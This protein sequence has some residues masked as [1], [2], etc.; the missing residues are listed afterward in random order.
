MNAALLL[1]KLSDIARLY[2][3]GDSVAMLNRVMDAQDLV[4]Q[5]QREQIEILRENGRLRER[6]EGSGA[7]LWV[8]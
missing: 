2:A 5:M 4:L 8:A 3:A 6:L 1:Q 7:T